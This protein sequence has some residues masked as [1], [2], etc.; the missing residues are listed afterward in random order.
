MEETKQHKLHI[1]AIRSD[2]SRIMDEWLRLHFRLTAVFVAVAFVVECLMAFV[3]ANS[4]ILNTTI[5][6]Y[7]F[8]FI[9]VP[10]GLAGL[11]LLTGLYTL[12]KK[13][14]SQKTK[15]Y[16]VSLLF[17]QIC[18]IYY[19]VHSAFFTVYS[20]YAFAIFLTTTYADYRLTGVVSLYS[21]ASLA[22]SELFFH[23][24][25][26]KV[27]VFTDSNRLVDFII[28]LSILIACS[29]ISIGTIRY[30]RRKNEA[31]LRRE[32]ERELLKESL[33]QDELTGVY[34]RKALHDALRKLEQAG[35]KAPLVFGIA[36]IDR[37]KAVN[38]VYG[39]QIGDL[40]LIEFS[41]ILS[42][43]FGESAVYR[44]GGDE[45]CLILHDIAI[46]EAVRLCERAQ[47]RLFRAEFA[48]APDLKPTACFGLT[49][50]SESGGAS[51]LFVQADEALYE[52]KKV[53]NA[54]HVYDGVSSAPFRQFVS[55]PL[56]DVITDASQEYFPD[57][58]PAMDD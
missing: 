53:R 23:W 42:E 15:A 5:G 11:C 54:I 31:S 39:H 41:C 19:T 43:C 52:S 58:V 34:N 24:D 12:Y 20:L 55:E 6:R 1:E 47:A 45:F 44:Y 56:M 50:F 16:V 17:A 3:I 7:I 46:D 28:A 9:A 21:I 18:F 2:L 32:V 26:D 13:N 29:I 22:V 25:I 36:D 57:R 8:K 27:S 37:F 35:A 14:L 10:S 49:E 48:G 4:D 30:E 33:R 51:R 38:D 40:C